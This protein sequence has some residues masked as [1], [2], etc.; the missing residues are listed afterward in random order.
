MSLERTITTLNRT[1]LEL[2][3]VPEMSKGIYDY[4]LNRTTLELKHSKYCE[5]NQYTNAL[6][7]TTLELKLKFKA[8]I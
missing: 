1:T 7:R 6:N 8:I 5:I 3:L 4:T 2:K